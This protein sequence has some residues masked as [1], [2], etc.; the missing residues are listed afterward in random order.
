MSNLRPYD[1]EETGDLLPCPFCGSKNVEFT[2]EHNL[3]YMEC[4]TCFAA[5]GGQNNYYES[6]KSLWNTRPLH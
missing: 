5:V 6:A 3:G 2:S 4:R 1:N